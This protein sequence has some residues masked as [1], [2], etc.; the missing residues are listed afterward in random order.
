MKLTY[1]TAGESHG[2]G[3]LALVEGYPAETPINVA[4]INQELAR[5]QGGYGRGGRQAIETD[6]ADILT[7]IWQ[8]RSIGSPIALW[9]PNKD[10]RLEGLEDLDSPRPGHGDLAGSLKYLGT[11]RGV[12]ERASARETAGRVAAG[13]LASGLL[14]MLGIQ[15][16]GYVTSIGKVAAPSVS[17]S[18]ADEI[19]ALR[20]KRDASA[21]YSLHPEQDGEFTTLIDEAREAGETLGGLME[22]VVTGLPIGLGTHAQWDDKLDGLLARAVM[23]VQAIK[24]VEIGVGVDAGRRLGSEM[25]DAIQY[26][27]SQKADHNLGYVR[28][29]NNAGGL[30]A[31]ITNG[32]P[33]LVRAAMKPIATLMQPIESV[34]WATKEK[35]DASYERSDVCAISAASVVLENVVAFEVATALLNKFASDT[36]AELKASIA[37]FEELASK[38]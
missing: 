29:T 14:E 28:P 18:K 1:K 30:E 26:D 20:D 21:V 22:V 6:Q 19:A 5:R 7:G 36:F 23:A 37:K 9:V 24:S 4:K 31:G 16:L 8:G 11:M 12:L 38:K 33:L 15:V 13:A 17:V 34:N 25:H 10:Y 2:K 27:A 3:I 32:Q 35:Q